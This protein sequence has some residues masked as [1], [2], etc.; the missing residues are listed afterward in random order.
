MYEFKRT[1]Q[2]FG[3]LE[4]IGKSNRSSR[5]MYWW[6]C[7]CSFGNYRTVEG[8]RLVKG[9]ITMGVK[10]QVKE[11]IEKLKASDIDQ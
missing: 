7:L 8:R 3:N 6:I 2:K 11:K 4:V 1:G 9:M 5:E 10:C